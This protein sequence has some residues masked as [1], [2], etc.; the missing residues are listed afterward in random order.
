MC[1]PATPIHV[2]LN[3]FSPLPCTKGM[4]M[5]EPIAP[6]SRL[7]DMTIAMYGSAFAPSNMSPSG[8]CVRGLRVSEG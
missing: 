4:R 5:S 3:M 7:I 8:V 6:P 2:A 1:T